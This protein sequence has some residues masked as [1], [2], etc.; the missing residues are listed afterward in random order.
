MSAAPFRDNLIFLQPSYPR[1]LYAGRPPP[2]PPRFFT[3]FCMLTREKII[4]ITAS[5]VIAIFG[6]GY[7]RFAQNRLSRRF[8]PSSS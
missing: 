1:L 5:H 2:A 4:L 7:R 3:V 8:L 6:R